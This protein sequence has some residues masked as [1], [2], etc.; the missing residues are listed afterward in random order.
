MT[1]QRGISPIP[2]M[3]YVDRAFA[4]HPSPSARRKKCKVGVPLRPKAALKHQAQTASLRVHPPRQPPPR[5]DQRGVSICHGTAGSRVTHDLLDFYRTEV[6]RAHSFGGAHQ[7]LPSG[8]D[9][10][11]DPNVPAY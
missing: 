4:S 7:Q 5:R 11:A 6:H 2:N 1:L 9:P 10:R 8:V 3:D